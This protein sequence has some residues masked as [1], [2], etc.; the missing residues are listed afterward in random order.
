ML[1]S[2]KL[3]PLLAALDGDEFA[4]TYVSFC[5]IVYYI[6]SKRKRVKNG[7]KKIKK[8]HSITSGCSVGGEPI[9]GG[10]LRYL[11]LSI[12]DFEASVLSNSG[13]L[14]SISSLDARP[15]L[16]RIAVLKQTDI[17]IDLDR[18]QRQ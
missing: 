16:S 7:Y 13:F 11:V 5:L 2:L 15:L 6:Y 10:V 12:E 9:G 17:I 8:N 1:T 4:R 14:T 3:L 18:Y